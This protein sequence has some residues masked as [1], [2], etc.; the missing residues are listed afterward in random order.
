MIFVNGHLL[1][2]VADLEDHTIIY[3]PTVEPINSKSQAEIIRVAKQ[4]QNV[5]II[6]E[7][8]TSGAFGDKIID[9][10]SQSGH[11]MSVKKLGIPRKFCLNYGTA[12]QHREEVGLT[13]QAILEALGV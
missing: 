12:D 5:V 1:D 3:S 11:R 2:T 4:H 13:K 10:V 9:L 7:N 8:S 6:E